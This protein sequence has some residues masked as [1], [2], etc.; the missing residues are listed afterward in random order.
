MGSRKE[1]DYM[2]GLP[3]LALPYRDYGLRSLVSGDS[4]WHWHWHNAV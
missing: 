4:L 2:M 1:Q 3:V